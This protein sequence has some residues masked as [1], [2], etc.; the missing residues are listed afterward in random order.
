LLGGAVIVMLAALFMCASR[1]GILSF[2]TVTIAQLLV[3]FGLLSA[4]RIR[5]ATWVYLIL[6]V[7]ILGVAVHITDWSNTLPRFQKIMRQDPHQNIRWKLFKDVAAM[8]NQLPLTGSGL[9]T[10][11]VAY[12]SFKTLDRQGLFRHAHNDY[13]E[14][15]A[16]MGWPGLVL[17]L[18]FSG[19]V[20]WRGSRVILKA[21]V[22]HTRGHPDLIQR[23]LLIS[24]SMGG[25][26][27]LLLHGLTDFN[28]RIPANA[29]TWFVLCGV[30]VGLSDL[31]EPR[32]REQAAGK[33][34]AEL[35]A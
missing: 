10:F 2:A 6:V 8:G 14:F 35:E 4:K 18:G 30:T 22:L 25:V 20:L 27:S 21:L 32:L 24:G 31:G 33:D 28:L 9:G 23:A 16:E 17:F 15:L 29:L 13:L 12:P 7:I 3:L 5:G 19:W 1:G 34:R 11:A 26:V